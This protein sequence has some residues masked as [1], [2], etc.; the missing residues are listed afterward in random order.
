M[1]P[2]FFKCGNSAREVVLR[3]GELGFNGAALFQVRKLGKGNPNLNSLAWLQWGRTFSSAEIRIP[4]KW[5]FISLRLQWGRTFSSAEISANFKIKLAKN[6]LQWGRTFSS[7]EIPVSKHG[8]L[9]SFA[10]FN[11]AA[12]FQVRKLCLWS[13]FSWWKT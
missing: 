13:S 12:L 2:H 3:S 9:E 11:G 7:A 10:G 8:R 5:A 6:R 1:G 4:C